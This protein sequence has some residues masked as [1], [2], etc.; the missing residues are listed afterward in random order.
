MRVY[1]NILSIS[2]L[3]GS[4]DYYTILYR[5]LNYR[6]STSSGRTKSPVIVYTFKRNKI[7]TCVELTIL[8]IVFEVEFTILSGSLKLLATRVKV[9]ENLIIIYLNCFFF[10]LEIFVFFFFLG[11]SN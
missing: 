11:K 4:L 5:D 9:S 10:T 8:P 3:S 7:K 1:E 2:G 6:L